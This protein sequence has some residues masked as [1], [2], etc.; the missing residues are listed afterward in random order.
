MKLVDLVPLQEIDFPTQKAFDAYSKQHKLR[1]T[2]KVKIAGKTTTAGQAA[3][4]SA[5]VKGTPVFNPGDRQKMQHTP[6]KKA[7]KPSLSQ[8]QFLADFMIKKIM[9]ANPVYGRTS[10]NAPAEVRKIQKIYN[11]ADA[12][13]AYFTKKK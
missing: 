7:E 4:K 13:I 1:P 12:L 3:Q 5:P 2:T 9:T 8:L 6:N 11:D 10:K